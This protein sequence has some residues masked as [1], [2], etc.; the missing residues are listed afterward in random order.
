MKKLV[1]GGTALLVG[2]D[3]ADAI[4]EYAA[5]LARAGSADTVELRAIDPSG[6]GVQAYY[7]L[8][9]TCAAM[10]QSTDSSGPEPD[11]TEI[12][13]YINAQIRRLDPNLLEFPLEYFGDSPGTEDDD[14]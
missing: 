6:R 1:V 7:A 3:A 10:A 14:D 5:V 2:D 12:V 8:T 11:N 13:N 4:V 9:A